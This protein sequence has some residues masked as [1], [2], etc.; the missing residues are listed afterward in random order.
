MFFDNPLRDRM[1]REPV[2]S[3]RRLEGGELRVP[4]APG[5]GIEVDRHAL[6]DMEARG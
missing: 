2:G 6:K 1:T 4:Q 3:A 5:L